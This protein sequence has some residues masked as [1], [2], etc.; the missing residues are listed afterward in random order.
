MPFIY[1]KATGEASDVGTGQGRKLVE[2]GTHA[3]NPRS[4]EGDA[5]AK[6]MEHETAQIQAE[7]ERVQLQRL[8]E[9]RRHR[10][11][12]ESLPPVERARMERFE[13]MSADAARGA[14]GGRRNVS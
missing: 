9:A 12:L 14:G 3:W 1:D 11:Y 10:D 6:A 5:G 4:L 2:A 7:N 8:Y 13:R